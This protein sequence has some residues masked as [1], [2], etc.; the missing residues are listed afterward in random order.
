MGLLGTKAFLLFPHF[1]F[2]GCIQPPQPSLSPKVAN[3]G[4]EGIQRQGR[5]SQET[6]VQPWG[7]V[8]VPPQGM[9]IFELFNRTKILNKWKMLTT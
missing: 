8:L 5:N 7:R 2:I 9:Y 4:R 3:Q 6:I 1:L